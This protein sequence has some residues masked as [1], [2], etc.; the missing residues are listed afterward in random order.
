VPI[1]SIVEAALVPSQLLGELF[2]EKGLISAEELEEALA[3]QKAHG[4]R[5]GEILVQKG[6]VSGPALTTVLAEQLGVEMEKQEGFGSGLWSEIKRRHPRGR[7]PERDAPAVATRPSTAFERRLALIDGMSEEVGEPQPVDWQQVDSDAKAQVVALEA[8]VAQLR[9]AVSEGHERRGE[10]EAATA[11]VKNELRELRAAV[12]S[13]EAELAAAEEARSREADARVAAEAELAQLQS[14]ALVLSQ[15][16]EETRNAQIAAR[17]EVGVLESR[18]AELEPLEALL[19]EANADGAARTQSLAELTVQLEAIQ[20][21]LA[22]RPE[23]PPVEEPAAAHV[24]FLPGAEGYSL[25]ERQGPAP[26]VGSDEEMDGVRLRVAR[27]GRSPLPAD[28][29]RCVFLE[30]A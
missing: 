8:E 14:D 22:E 15:S 7:A 20:A 27:I 5:L 6:F 26:E 30:V 3:E 12:E 16:L 24:V 2:V 17:R 11:V 1:S 10:A 29:R 28:V 25:T 9:E 13:R 4:K 18:C 19:A 21:D 23:A